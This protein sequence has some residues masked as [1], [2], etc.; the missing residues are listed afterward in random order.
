MIDAWKDQFEDEIRLAETP[1]Q[2]PHREH[3]DRDQAELQRPVTQEEPTPDVE[4]EMPRQGYIFCNIMQY[5]GRGG[6]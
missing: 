2:A 4:C 1:G 6:W 5:L 3:V